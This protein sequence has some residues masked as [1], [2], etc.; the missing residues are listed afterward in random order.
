MFALSSPAFGPGAPIAEK[1]ALHAH[2]AGAGEPSIPY[3]WTAPPAGTRSFALSLVDHAPVAHEWV[4]WLVIDVPATATGLPEGASHSATLPSGSRE[5][6]NGF[7]SIGYGGPMPPPGSGAHP[8]EATVYALD[9]PTIDL[10][11]RASL[12]QFQQAI[13]GHVLG[14]ATYT[15]TFQR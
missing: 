4:H 9:V 6:A 14:Q 1:Y 13:A 3:V 15:G 7:G 10:P 12:A 11:Q 2:G 5:L 8:Y